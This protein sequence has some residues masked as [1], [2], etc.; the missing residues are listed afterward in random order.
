M[1]HASK[2]NQGYPGTMEREMG[3]FTFTFERAALLRTV[4]AHQSMIVPSVSPVT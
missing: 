4:V 2:V 3:H 1:V